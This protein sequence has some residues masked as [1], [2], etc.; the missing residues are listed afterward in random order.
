MPADLELRNLAKS[1]GA[2][3]VVN[4]VSLE[5][6]AG[7]FLAL[8]GP[9][10]C[11]KTTI[12]RMIAGFVRPTMG[13]ILLGGQDVTRLPPDRR[14]MGMVFQNY[15]LF[16]HMSVERNVMFGLACHGASKDEARRQAHAALETV[17]LGEHIEKMSRQLSGGQQQ[18]VALARVLALKP[19]LLL[20]D[21]PLSN[22]D[23][24]LR[25]QM[26][27]E[28]RRL[29]REIGT[30]TIFVTHDQEEAMAIADRIVILNRGSVEQIGT[31]GDIYDRPRT[32][33]VADF[34]GTSN[35]FTGTPA[36]HNGRS[37][38]ST[39]TGL[40]LDLPPNAL[41][42]G[43]TTVAIR[44]EQVTLAVVN[45]PGTLAGEVAQAIHLGPVMQY[46]VAL[47]SGDYVK[48][49]AQRHGAGRIW[50]RGDAVGVAWRPED[51]VV[52]AS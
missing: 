18:R 16:P 7:E 30:T 42:T 1:Y 49:S 45:T 48:V 24:K 21:E 10:G 25:I 14:G 28:I 9:S 38:L 33:F 39:A 36:A 27:A 13:T 34:I 12:L 35:F 52:I 32:R 11:G 23:A 5:L 19:A 2:V 17:G 47:V 26:R 44:P 31:T 50:Q 51:I 3:R 37:R 15:A 41:S 6:A 46:E 40:V 4:D 43:E 20:F 22:L 29:Q 8:L